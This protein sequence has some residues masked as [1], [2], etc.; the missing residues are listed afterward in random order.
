MQARTNEGR[1]SRMLMPVDEC[2]GYLDAV[3][4]IFQHVRQQL[5]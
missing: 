2:R 3:L 4:G 1:S 5:Y